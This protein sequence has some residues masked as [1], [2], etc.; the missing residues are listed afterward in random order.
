M[1]SATNVN[2]CHSSGRQLIAPQKA[3]VQT[4]SDTTGAP[5][6]TASTSAPTQGAKTKVALAKMGIHWM[7]ALLAPATLKNEFS[8]QFPQLAVTPKLR[9][10]SQ[11]RAERRGRREI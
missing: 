8:P 6:P 4:P 11:A 9:K 10:N 5:N 2:Q 3:T 7:R 1:F